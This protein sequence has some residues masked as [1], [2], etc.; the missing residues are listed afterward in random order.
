MPPPLPH[1]TPC[2]PALHL[3]HR[4]SNPHSY[5]EV[6]SFS[7]KGP[8]KTPQL[9]LGPLLNVGYNDNNIIIIVI[10]SHKKHLID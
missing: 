3:H 6:S 4:I 5:S 9:V 1:S 7:K 8:S 10:N 2:I